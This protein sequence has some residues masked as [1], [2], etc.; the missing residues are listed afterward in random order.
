MAYQ[1]SFMDSLYDN[2]AIIKGAYPVLNEHNYIIIDPYD[3]N[4]DGFTFINPTKN[5]CNQLAH[6]ERN[7]MEYSFMLGK[8]Y[9]CGSPQTVASR[10][11]TNAHNDISLFLNASYILNNRHQLFFSNILTKKET[12]FTP[13][14]IFWDY[15]NARKTNNMGALFLNEANLDST[16]YPILE[17]WQRAFTPEEVGKNANTHLFE[18]FAAI[19]AGI[20]GEAFLGFDYE[21]SITF[22]QNK[23]KQQRTLIHKKCADRFFLDPLLRKVN[24]NGNIWNIHNAP[25]H[26]FYRALTPQEYQ[27]ISG[28]DTTY[29]YAQNITHSLI[30]T[31]EALMTLPA[32]DL[33]L[34]FVVE[35]AYQKYNIELDPRLIN[36]EWRSTHSSGGEENENV[37][38]SH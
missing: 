33:S 26:R 18:N 30:L 35:M 8:G 13:L 34:A 31:N 29:A 32:G 2:F 28:I 27:S 9:Y 22:S 20:K 25:H 24:A 6:L 5:V 21:F 17:L 23:I 38:P 16:G 1:R 4:K 12:E 14:S 11:L 36:H 7:S 19:T 37:Q 3:T 10:S 15:E